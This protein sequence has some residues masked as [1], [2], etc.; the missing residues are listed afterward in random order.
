[1][2]RAAIERLLRGLE[3]RKVLTIDR[4]L[5]SHVVD[6]MVS[7]WTFWLALDQVE[8]THASGPRLIHNTVLQFM[9][10]IVPHMGP[11]G[12]NYLSEMLER[13]ERLTKPLA[14]VR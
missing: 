4:R 7:T 6:R 10:L 11:T 9:L 14:S 12:A 8:E 13:H 3:R 1:M 2:K 5:K